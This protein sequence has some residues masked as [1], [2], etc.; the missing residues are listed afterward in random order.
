M[1]LVISALALLVFIHAA[2]AQRLRASDHVSFYVAPD[3]T[4]FGN[5]CLAADQPCRTAQS[6]S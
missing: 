2:G 5:T 1:K 3:G 4:D 6:V